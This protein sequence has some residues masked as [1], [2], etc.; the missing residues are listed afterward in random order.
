MRVELAKIR[1]ELDAKAGG[2]EFGLKDIGGMGNES[3]S[4]D[5]FPGEGEDAS[6][7]ESDIESSESGDDEIAEELLSVPSDGLCNAVFS[8]AMAGGT[9]DLPRGIT[10]RPSG[11]WVSWSLRLLCWRYHLRSPVCSHDTVHTASSALLR[12]ELSVHWSL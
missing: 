9:G 10:I 8:T 2:G 4:L 12:R 6:G 11:K 1:A 3:Y 5:N 7:D